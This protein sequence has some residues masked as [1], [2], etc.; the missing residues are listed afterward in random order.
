MTT[1][2]EHQDASPGRVAA[3]QRLPEIPRSAHRA[4]AAPTVDAVPGSQR[5]D[6]RAV[7]DFLDIS[8]T[9]SGSTTVSDDAPPGVYASY[10]PVILHHLYAGV[11]ADD[12][13]RH[14]R[15]ARSLMGLEEAP[16]P[17]RDRDVVRALLKW[18]ATR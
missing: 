15:H 8:G 9:P 11:S 10:A 12:I 5:D 13:L 14:L 3:A 2:A 16:D 18:W 6:E 17:G 4:A 7:S 1:A